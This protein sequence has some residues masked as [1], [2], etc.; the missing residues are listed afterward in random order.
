[1]PLLRGTGT[2]VNSQRMVSLLDR[3]MQALFDRDNQIDTWKKLVH[4]V[5]WWD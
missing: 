2:T 4:P 5:K 1:M 3:A